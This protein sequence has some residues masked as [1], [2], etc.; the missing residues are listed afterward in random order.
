M[1]RTREAAG[2]A[3]DLELLHQGSISEDTFR[4]KHDT[5]GGLTVT[6]VVWP[7]LEHFLCDGDIRATDAKYRTMQEYELA[8]LVALLRAGAPDSELCRIHFLGYS[9]VTNAA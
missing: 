9:E 1:S 2:L 7:Y 5:P 8:K 4:A 3:D 6:A